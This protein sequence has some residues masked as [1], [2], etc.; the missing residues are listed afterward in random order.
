MLLPA[1]SQMDHSTCAPFPRSSTCSTLCSSRSVSSQYH[2]AR[3]S[4]SSHYRNPRRD[5]FAFDRT[6]YRDA[7]CEVTPSIIF[8]T[9]A[10]A[11]RFTSRR[12]DVAAVAE[13]RLLASDELALV[14]SCRWRRRNC[15]RLRRRVA[16]AQ[17][18]VLLD[19]RHRYA[20]RPFALVLRVDHPQQ[21][22][23]AVYAARVIEYHGVCAGV[24]ANA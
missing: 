20:S 22:I 19:C 7:S 4:T 18:N 1:A 12:I 8:L 13:V 17:P 9:K 14:H 2:D 6:L 5:T 21:L 15:V 16:A 11:P 23:H 3:H 10:A 24:G